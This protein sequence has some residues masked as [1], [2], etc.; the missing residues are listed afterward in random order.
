[1]RSARQRKAP[2]IL[3]GIRQP[4][5]TT[6]EK[7]HRGMRV[8]RE[9]GARTLGGRELCGQRAGTPDVRFNGSEAPLRQTDCPSVCGS[10]GSGTRAGQV[11]LNQPI[12]LELCGSHARAKRLRNLH[13]PPTLLSP[14]RK[15]AGRRVPIVF[16]PPRDGVPGA[17]GR[18]SPSRRFA[19]GETLRVRV[20]RAVPAYPGDT[21]RLPGAV[22]HGNAGPGDARGRVPTAFRLP[23]TEGRSSSDNGLPTQGNNSN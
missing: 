7:P 23:G 12:I 11:S 15:P 9:S 4:R 1:M 13:Q 8:F 18:S 17:P 16:R 19:R 21:C 3:Y 6:S 5:Q 2:P 20:S 10:G 14:T 22:R